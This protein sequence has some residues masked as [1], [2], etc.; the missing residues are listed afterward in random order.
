MTLFIQTDATGVGTGVLDA[1]EAFV[2]LAVIANGDTGLGFTDVS[3]SLQQITYARTLTG[4]PPIRL[5][6]LVNTLFGVNPE[7]RD[8]IIVPVLDN[9]VLP[10]GTPIGRGGF[11]LPPVGSDMPSAENNPTT[12]CLVVYN[13]TDRNG[14][15]L[16]FARAGSGGTKDLPISNPVTLYHE[17]SHASRIVNDALLEVTPGVCDPASPEESAAIVEENDMRTQI[18]NALGVAPELRDPLIHCARKGCRGDGC[19]IVATVASGSHLSVEVDALRSVRDGY[20]RRSEAGFAFFARLHDAYYGFS[21]EVV[22]L[23][24]RHTG[25]QEL[26]LRSYVRPLVVALQT[27]ERYTLGGLRGAELARQLCAAGD[28]I[29]EPELARALA[30]LDGDAA[31]TAELPC[32]ERELS[33]TL[34]A[35][36]LPDPHVRWALVD[37]LFL[38][39]TARRAAGMQL[40]DEELGRTLAAAI[41]EWAARLPIEDFWP[42]LTRSE[43]TGELRFLERSLLVTARARRRF[44]ARL[45]KAF[46]QARTIHD[47]LADFDGEDQ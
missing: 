41:D 2:N 10:D 23:I 44:G 38:Y 37:S 9:F 18:A 11:A 20:L 16:C 17:L 45:A 35:H 24:A 19:C 22:R 6:T 28:E 21:P 1:P 13:T 14:P 47:A 30:L 29:S 4:P 5:D 7:N 46:P 36:A 15:G 3:P 12:S 43:V 26:V 33:A 8:I 42:S 27:I 40:T 25:L 31:A 32:G 39:L 34:I